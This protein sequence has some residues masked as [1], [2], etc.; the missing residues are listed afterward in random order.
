MLT[1]NLGEMLNNCLF[2]EPVHSVRVRNGVYAHQYR[3]GVIN[4]DGTK[5]V[6]HSMSSAIKE[7]KKKN[8]RN[9][10]RTV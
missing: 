6:M 8:G 10:H 2:D 5:Y 7:F 1:L 3:N 4:I 9:K